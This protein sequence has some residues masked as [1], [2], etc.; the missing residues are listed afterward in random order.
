M[1][2]SSLG[3]ADLI[4][5][6]EELG[7]EG[8]RNKTKALII[9]AIRATEA[10]AAELA[11]SLDLAKDRQRKKLEETER[12]DRIRREEI[13]IKK[14]DLELKK[15]QTKGRR[16]EIEVTDSKYLATTFP[17]WFRYKGDPKPIEKDLVSREE[18][19][20]A[21]SRA[22]T[23]QVAAGTAGERERVEDEESDLTD[24]QRLSGDGTTTAVPHFADSKLEAVEVV[25]DSYP[26]KER[27]E[28]FQASDVCFLGD[29]GKASMETP[30]WKFIQLQ[31]SSAEMS[32]D[33]EAEQD[34][35]RPSHHPW[36]SDTKPGLDKQD[37]TQGCSTKA[38]SSSRPSGKKKQKKQRRRVSVLR[39]APND[40]DQ[41]RHPRRDASSQKQKSSS[42]EKGE[43]GGTHPKDPS[44]GSGCEAKGS[45]EDAHAFKLDKGDP[46]QGLSGRSPGSGQPSK[47]REQERRPHKVSVLQSGPNTSDGKRHRGLDDGRSSQRQLSSRPKT[48]PKDSST[49]SGC[50]TKGSSRDAYETTLD[51]GNPSQRHSETSSSSQNDPRRLSRPKGHKKKR[52]RRV[53]DLQSVPDSFT[54]Q[55]R[56]RLKRRHFRKRKL[57]SELGDENREYIHPKKAS[58]D[59]GWKSKEHSSDTRKSN[60]T[61]QGGPRQRRLRRRRCVFRSGPNASDKHRDRRLSARNSRLFSSGLGES[62]RQGTYPKEQS[63][64]GTTS[65]M[66]GENSRERTRDEEASTQSLSDERHKSCEDSFIV[67]KPGDKPPKFATGIRCEKRILIDGMQEHCL[68]SLQSRPTTVQKL[69]TTFT[70]VTQLVRVANR[71]HGLK[72]RDTPRLAQ[73]LVVSRITYGTPY[74][75]F[76]TSEKE[77]INV[78]IRKSYK[79][80][81]GLPPIAST[82]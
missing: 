75:G 60:L 40:S 6:C 10:D 44:T 69:Q 7:V 52:Q 65:N 77:K 1:N 17:H 28:A 62:K 55:R 72:E 81:M 13:E 70:Q 46:S 50:E 33:R 73:A 23:R 68:T 12:S 36:D 67:K 63:I 3:K 58:T 51:E 9:E 82:E 49:S 43:R 2:L 15:C 41:Q 38:S 21:P 34:S 26:A 74:L 54:E 18:R 27:E 35:G 79:L 16:V 76:R 61:E 64:S 30:P 66:P 22:R 42:P 47:Q 20:L 56:K 71:K 31:E 53:S 80:A 32:V 24:G 14:L 19:V 48:N 8:V 37:P 59:S 45:S 11:E 25:G 4:L 39:P 5:I 29:K 78:L 57:S